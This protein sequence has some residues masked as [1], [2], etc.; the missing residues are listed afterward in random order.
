MRH[1]RQFPGPQRLF[2]H[3]ATY[4]DIPLSGSKEKVQENVQKQK[5]D[6]R[7]GGDNDE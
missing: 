1:D 5:Q 7:R 6:V 4:Q 3:A 2:T